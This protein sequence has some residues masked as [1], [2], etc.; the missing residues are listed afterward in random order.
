M[1]AGGGRSRR[2]ARCRRRG[3]SRP[4]RKIFWA[5]SSWRPVTLPLPARRTHQA[6]DAA[7]AV[8]ADLDGLAGGGARHGA[9]RRGG[10]ARAGACARVAPGGAPAANHR[11]R[12]RRRAGGERG[13]EGV[14]AEGRGRYDAGTRAWRPTR[15]VAAA[16]G[17]RQRL[18]KKA[19][20]AP[21][22]AAGMKQGAARRVR[23]GARRE[24]RARRRRGGAIGGRRRWT[25]L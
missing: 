3:G 5:L 13:K 24:A 11:A 9:A 6:P 16:R 10:A 2:S 1:W 23:T 8:D 22:S 12:R 7:E 4:K 15:A 18:G 19:R 21:E 25:W 20:A 17:A 14:S